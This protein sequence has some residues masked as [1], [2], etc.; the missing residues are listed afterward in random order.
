MKRGNRWSVS[1]LIL[2]V[3]LLVAACGGS[4]TDAA[5]EPATVE[6]VAGTDLSRVTLTPRRP[7]G[8]TSRRRAVGRKRAR[9]GSSRTPPLVYYPTGET[10][11]YTKPEAAHVRPA[12]IVVDRIDG[13][14]AFS[15]R[16]RAPG[17]RW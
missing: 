17:R 13:D 6:E 14:R 7:S 16:D 4:S 5:I 2:V 3:P 1:V 10:W 12:A 8:S 15:R 9:R 11:A